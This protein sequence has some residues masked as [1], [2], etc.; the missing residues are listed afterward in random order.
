MGASPCWSFLFHST[1][2]TGEVEWAETLTAGD[3]AGN[4]KFVIVQPAIVQDSTAIAG[5]PLTSWTNGG[6]LRLYLSC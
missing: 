6:L 3:I 4:P 2:M 1:M 5:M